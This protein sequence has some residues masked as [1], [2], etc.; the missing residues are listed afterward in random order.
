MKMVEEQFKTINTSKNGL[1][2]DN[3]RKIETFN[4]QALKFSTYSIVDIRACFG[5][6]P[7]GK[8]YYEI[9]EILHRL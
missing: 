9:P 8:P 6:G 4:P 5:Q 7:Q 3:I 2:Y 1:R